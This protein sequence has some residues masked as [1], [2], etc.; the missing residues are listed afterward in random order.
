MWIWR[1]LKVGDENPADC[2]SKLC[3]RTRSRSL[4]RWGG[5]RGGG[6]DCGCGEGKVGNEN[7]AGSQSKLCHRTRL[8]SMLRGVVVMIVDMEK[9]KDQMTKF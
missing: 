1:R 8:W 9:V 7:P 6:Y 5:G 3:H 4:L 2:Q